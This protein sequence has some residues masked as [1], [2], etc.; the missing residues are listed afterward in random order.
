[1]VNISH[2]NGTPTSFETALKDLL[3]YQRVLTE[4]CGGFFLPPSG[5]IVIKEKHGAFP[6]YAYVNYPKCMKNIKHIVRYGHAAE[7]ISARIS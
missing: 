6:L 4:K 7:G 2:G 3:N 1:M 5:Y